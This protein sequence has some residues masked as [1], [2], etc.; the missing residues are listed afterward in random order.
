MT[1]PPLGQN[2]FV[3]SSGVTR[4]LFTF[5]L[6]LD[7]CPVGS[8]WDLDLE[9]CSFCPAGR[10]GANIGLATANCSG[11]CPAGYVCPSGT[12]TPEPCLPGTY[13]TGSG[14]ACVLCPLATPYSPALSA[15]AA[16][17]TSCSAG[18]EAGLHGAAMCP[19]AGDPSVWQ[20]WYDVTGVEGANSCLYLN[21]TVGTWGAAKAA[22][23]AMDAAAHLLTLSTGG[24]PETNALALFAASLLEPDT[25]AFVGMIRDNSSPPWGWRWLDLSV[26]G[27][28]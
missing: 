14:S 2:Q 20:V 10:F 23:T 11:P 7:T 3:A 25:S 16:N 12:S 8:W 24:R 28:L 5:T 4:Q 22:C 19:R 27:F 6:E 13:A 21:S 9:L 17:C 26:S 18:C 1:P 15:S